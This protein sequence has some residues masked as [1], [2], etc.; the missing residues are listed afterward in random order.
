MEA[1]MDVVIEDEKFDPNIY[2]RTKDSYLDEW[3]GHSLAYYGF[4]ALG[5]DY[6]AGRAK[7][8]DLE[9]DQSIVWK[10]IWNKFGF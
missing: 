8:V 2:T 6:F 7:D 10:I 9:S 5:L 3:M 4:D 1:V